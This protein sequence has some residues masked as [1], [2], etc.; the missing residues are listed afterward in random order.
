MN[1]TPCQRKTVCGHS[2]YFQARNIEYK[3]PAEEEWALF[4][5][6]IAVEL[7]TAQDLATEDQQEATIGRQ[8]EEVD[9]QME[10]WSRVRSMEKKLDTVVEGAKERK[11]NAKEDSSD[12]ED[13]LDAEDLNDWRKKK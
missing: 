2:F 4:Q 13:E 7:D 5:K 3:D 6:E 12:S 1:E 9:E 8:M 11:D 10:A